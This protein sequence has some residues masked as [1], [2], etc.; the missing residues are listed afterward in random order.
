M[1]LLLFLIGVKH[2]FERRVNLFGLLEKLI[3]PKIQY[4]GQTSPLKKGKV[5]FF[6]SL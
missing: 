5:D 4:G 6:K 1:L 3:L 2:S